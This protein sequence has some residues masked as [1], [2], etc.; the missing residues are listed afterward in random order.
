[1]RFVVVVLVLMFV[2]A[3][4]LS[5][6]LGD[7]E[8]PAPDGD[9]GDTT[10][11]G[12]DPEA[13]A[14][15]SIQGVV[16][17]A[18]FK[19]IEDARVELLQSGEYVDETTTAANGSYSFVELEPGEY[20]L[21]FGA[22]CCQE[23]SRGAIVKA[24]TQESITVNLEP[25]RSLEPYVERLVWEGF[26]GCSAFIPGYGIFF[27]PEGACANNDPNND[28]LH[29]FEIQ[30]GLASVVVAMEWTQETTNPFN[31]LQI[32]MSKGP[33]VD[34]R[35]SNRF[36]TLA[37]PPVLETTIGPEDAEAGEELYFD[38]IEEAWDVRF[39]VTASDS[40]IFVY[41]QPFKVYYDL[42]Y[43][44]PAPEGASALPE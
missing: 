1:M 42:Y 22:S 18:S 23:L 13:V 33:F 11:E 44:E 39:T 12:K 24:G 15:G 32:V 29:E 3:P 34:D 41:Q 43:R 8:T 40:G 25:R 38:K 19:P 5:G 20:R 10:D 9:E 14:T 21:K 35:F 2:A 31:D 27:N 36:F 17:D 37:G 26:I 28:P 4:L 6:C 16:A 7:E 30:P